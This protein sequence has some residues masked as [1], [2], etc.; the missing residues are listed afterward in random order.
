M[1][2]GI[3]VAVPQKFR[4][5][6]LQMLHEVLAGIVRMKEIAISYVWWPGLNQEIEFVAKACVDCQAG[7][8]E[9]ARASLYP[10][11]RPDKPW[12]RVC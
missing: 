9:P 3:K 2:W 4:K 11:I 6:V 12:L 7:K 1:L 10:W 8:S 5:D